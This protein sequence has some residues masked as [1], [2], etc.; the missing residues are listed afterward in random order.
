MA[1]PTV[2]GRT[3]SQSVANAT[4]HTVNF[5]TTP[6]NGDLL[7]VAVSFD[8]SG[9]TV[10]WPSG[11]TQPTNGFV[12]GSGDITEVRYKVASSATSS[13]SISTNNSEEGEFRA[14]RIAAGTYT[15]TPEVTQTTGNSG[16][17]NSPNL[18]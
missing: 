17:P 8:G 1:F 12:T 13:I 4:S 6:T 15:G 14:W 9:T 10:T 5:D 3:N 18:A 7:V 16:T 11:W 2:A